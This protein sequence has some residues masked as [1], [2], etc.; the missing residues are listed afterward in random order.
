MAPLEAIMAWHTAICLLLIHGPI[1]CLHT[2]GYQYRP[3]QLKAN[4][5]DYAPYIGSP[6]LLL[7]KVG[8]LLS[9]V[10]HL[11]FITQIHI[12]LHGGGTF[13][14]VTILSVVVFHTGLTGSPIPFPHRC[15]QYLLYNVFWD[16]T[17]FGIIMKSDCYKYFQ[18]CKTTACHASLKIHY[19]DKTSFCRTTPLPSWP[20]GPV[21][22]LDIEKIIWTL[23]LTVIVTGANA[24]PPFLIS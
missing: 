15:F 7:T 10:G 8:S 24:K 6:A 17:S 14:Y 9:Y 23:C 4:R 1:S 2:S 20:V 19:Y 16:W 5:L 3:A 11:S 21:A 12:R 22:W 18:D 13:E